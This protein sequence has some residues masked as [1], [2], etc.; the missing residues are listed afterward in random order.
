MLEL[1]VYYKIETIKIHY[2][3]YYKMASHIETEQAQQNITLIRHMLEEDLAGFGDDN[4]EN[5]ASIRELITDDINALNEFVDTEDHYQ[6]DAINNTVNAILQNR[7][8]L[9][10]ELVVVEAQIESGDDIE[11]AMFIRGI[12]VNDIAELDN[13]IKSLTDFSN[14]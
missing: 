13:Q 5:I 7:Q 4:A 9:Q 3:Q 14:E 8:A 11:N 10:N 1:L 6:N 2:Q 12:L